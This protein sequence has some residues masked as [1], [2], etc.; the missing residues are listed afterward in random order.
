MNSEPLPEEP[1][2]CTIPVTTVLNLHQHVFLQCPYRVRVPCA[3]LHVLQRH[4]WLG[5]AKPDS[6]RTKT[7]ISMPEHFGHGDAHWRAHLEGG[8]EGHTEEILTTFR[9][10]SAS[11]NYSEANCSAHLLGVPPAAT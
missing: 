7:V 3:V 6:Q 10:P 1:N 11:V 4:A 9:S 2:I 8:R 5:A